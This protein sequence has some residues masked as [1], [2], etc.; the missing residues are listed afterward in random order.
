[1]AGHQPHPDPRG[2]RAPGGLRAR[3]ERA[4]PLHARGAPGPPRRPGRLPGRRG[5]AR[6][7]RRRW[8]WRACRAPSS[9]PWR[10]PTS[11]SPPRSRAATSTRRSPPTTRSTTSSSTPSANGEIA[12]S[13][14]RLMP[15]LRRLE[16]LRFG[17]LVGRRSVEQHAAIVERCAARR[18][19][20]AAEAVA[21]ELALPRNPDRSE[22]HVTDA[23]ASPAASL[24][25]YERYPLLFGPSPVHRLDAADRAPRRRARSGP[26][27][28]TSTPGSPSAATRRASSSTSS[29]TRSRRAATRSSRSAA[30]S[31]TT[32]ARSPPRP[33][34]LGL[35][36]A[37]S[38]RR[39]GSTG[40]TP[41][42]TASATSCSAASWAPR[43][44]RARRLRHRLQGELG[45]GARRRRAPRGGTPYAIPAGASDHPLGGL[46]FA[47]WAREVERAGARARRLLRH[48]RRVLG[49]RQHAGRA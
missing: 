1:M 46:G 10:R 6:A 4:Q 29:P 45:A 18:R 2:P 8:G 39:A 5:A 3:R 9:T 44:A 31:P 30:C 48:D 33:R 34:A 36:A 40:P 15:R 7:W 26:S 38:C 24:E 43:S 42:T 22:L 27:A 14:E 49:D 20:G 23:V 21:R 41:S 11:A 28:R 25:A 19:S 13:L 37:C 17:S 47:S 32:R 16:R 35:K 12:R